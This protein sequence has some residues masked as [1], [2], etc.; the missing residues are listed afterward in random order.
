MSSKKKSSQSF[1][2]FT[3]ITYIRNLER[4]KYIYA[5][6]P[7]KKLALGT[8][9]CFCFLFSPF[10]LSGNKEAN[11]ESRAYIYALEAGFSKLP[12]IIKSFTKLLDEYF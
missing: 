6:P 11:R 9:L 2:I 3:N 10:H 12:K 7:L 1:G 5:L 8:L 4:E